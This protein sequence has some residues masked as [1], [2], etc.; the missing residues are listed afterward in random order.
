[1]SGTRLSL[2]RF[3]KRGFF[4]EYRTIVS[5][6]FGNTWAEQEID[7]GVSTK[8][9]ISFVA[10]RVPLVIASGFK[11]KRVHKDAPRH[12]AIAA[13]VFARHAHP[14]AMRLMQG[15]H[16]RADHAPAL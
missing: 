6:H 14:L 16:A 11:L 13:S 12:F 3:R 15:A 8:F 10:S 1:M 5:I 7:T 9:L 2:Q 4:D